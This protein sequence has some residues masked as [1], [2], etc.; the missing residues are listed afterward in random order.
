M[1]R[2]LA[3]ILLSVAVLSGCGQEGAQITHE[4]S[5]FVDVLK[6]NGVDG[7]S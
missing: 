7:N 3:S 6:E 1:K 5:S 2:L 4:L